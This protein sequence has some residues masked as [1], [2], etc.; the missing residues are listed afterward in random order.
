MLLIAIVV[1]VVLIGYWPPQSSIPHNAI[2]HMK[3]I[4]P[5]GDILCTLKM[6]KEHLKIL[7]FSIKIVKKTKNVYSKYH[8]TIY[9]IK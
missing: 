1:F 4:S 8:N 5:L 3:M 6:F 7:Y 9:K 2:P